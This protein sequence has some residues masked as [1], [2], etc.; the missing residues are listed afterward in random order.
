MKKKLKKRLNIAVTKELKKFDID[1]ARLDDDFAFYYFDNTITFKLDSSDKE[2]G[3]FLEF[4]AKRFNFTTD[5][6]FIL[7]LLHEVGHS[8]T[9]NDIVGAVNDFCL[10][11]RERIMLGVSSNITTEERKKLNFEY[12]NLPDEIMATAWA[13][14]Y[15]KEHPK[16]IKK[17]RK[18]L[19]EAGVVT[20]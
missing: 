13:V 7:F 4:V 3:Y 8:M 11:E 20:K 6:P 1:K 12:F 19:E 15:I 10:V 2:D 17:M 18:R 9:E 5:C 14:D 16:K